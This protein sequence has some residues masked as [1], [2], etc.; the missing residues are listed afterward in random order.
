[1][2]RQR[3]S[4]PRKT[5]ITNDITDASANIWD[6]ISYKRGYIQDDLEPIPGFDDW[7]MTPD[8]PV[9]PRD[10]NRYPNSPWC[11]G[12]GF[13]PTPIDIGFDW[14]ADDCNFGV[15]V[16]PTLAFV[17]LPCFQLVYRNPACIPDPPLQ[18]P[19]P[20]DPDFPNLI[21][22]DIDPEKICFVFLN[23]SQTFRLYYYVLREDRE[24]SIFEVEG[25][26]NHNFSWINFFCPGRGLQN[27]YT[28]P[29]G[30]NIF[31]PDTNLI[32]GDAFYE[33]SHNGFIHDEQFPNTSG[34]TGGSYSE[35]YNFDAFPTHHPVTLLNAD[36]VG[37]ANRGELNFYLIG[38]RTSGRNALNILDSVFFPRSFFN[39]VLIHGKWGRIASAI[40]EMHSDSNYSLAEGDNTY[41]Y[42]RSFV[43]N[44]TIAKVIF[45]DC[46]KISFPPPPPLP[47]D[48]DKDC[49]MACCD[50]TLLKLLYKKV[51]KIAQII[52][53][54][55]YPVSVPESLISKDEGFIGNLIP[56]P[57]KNLQ[58]LTQ[59]FVWYIERFDELMGQFEIPIEIKDADPTTPGDQ[60][61][62]I[63]LPNVAE[64]IAEMMG[65]LLEAAINSR[66]L[67]NIT[68]RNLIG[69][70]QDKLQNYKT[71]MATQAIIEYLGFKHKDTKEKIPMLITPD[72]ESLE[73]LLQ[74]KE[75]EIE[76]T[77][78]D[79]KQTFRE[80]LADLLN[81]AA[82]IRAVFWRKIDKDKDIAA[83]LVEKIK[84][85]KDVDD[86]LAKN[87]KDDD[88]LDKFIADVEDGFRSYTNITDP[89]NPYGKPYEERPKIKKIGDDTLGSK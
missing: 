85:L 40:R 37:R 2:V 42:E 3:I 28:E 55:D 5:D 73:E 12:T 65:L 27:F 61:V 45:E 10:C 64:S 52:G 17:S 88:D 72:K 25:T 67:V 11:G 16:C 80:N 54:D 79:D 21:L 23:W 29:D 71:Y 39:V 50:D 13:S 53:V 8:D 87:T 49:C 82:I 63:K 70:E 46:Q 34:D 43:T 86:A 75:F 6:A 15:Q 35:S 74:E 58:S 84:K 19:D 18:Q 36:W 24:Q 41:S 76:V 78:F 32:S 60:P 81:A 31:Y 62:G 33:S 56:N 7:Y 66:T 83:Q 1:M 4:T 48:N 9:D 26:E 44:I 89:L 14:V 30:N 77:N 47:S 59:L 38:G 51:D 69:S 22:P 68:T 20:T 57:N